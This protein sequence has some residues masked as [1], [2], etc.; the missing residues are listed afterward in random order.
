MPNKPLRLADALKEYGREELDRL[1]AAGDA[2]VKALLPPRSLS[3][4]LPLE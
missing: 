3:V 2:K 4:Q 1:V